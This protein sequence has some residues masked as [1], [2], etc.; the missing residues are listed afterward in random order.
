MEQ[1]CDPQ[2]KARG[3]EKLVGI[4]ESK[5]NTL[6]V[7]LDAV[8]GRGQRDQDKDKHLSLHHTYDESLF[9]A[10]RSFK[11]PRRNK[12]LMAAKQKGNL[13]QLF[14]RDAYKAGNYKS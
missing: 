5:N 6:M 14:V 9:R 3:K 4:V 2:I 8:N 11:G 13:I 12:K 7:N 1:V 10:L